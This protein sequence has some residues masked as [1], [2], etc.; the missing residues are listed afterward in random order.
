MII[1]CPKCSTKFQLEESLARP[2]ARARCNFCGHVFV[3][4][5]GMDNLAFE[6]ISQTGA[7][8][9]KETVDAIIGEGLNYNVDKIQPKK[10]KKIFPLILILLILI[11]GGAGAAVYTGL[12]P[13]DFFAEKQTDKPAITDSNATDAISTNSNATGTTPPQPPQEDASVKD[14]ILTDVRMFY[15]NNEKIGQLFVIEGKATN[16]FKTPKELIKVEATL[17]D[18][19]EHVLL[20]KQQFCGVVVSMFQL[21]V[22]SAEDLDKA[23][24]NKIEI[25]SN[26]INLQPGAS[27]PFMIVFT[28]APTTVREFMLKIID[29][30][31]PSN[32]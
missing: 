19:H 21:Q 2:L 5:D 15:V 20:S 30:K 10:R 1:T 31:D 17:L 11:L 7:P 28:D 29:A 24:N 25:L 14:I 4:A 3:M 32:S 6:A 18:E 9:A 12:I 13:L 27:V 26:N 23:L 8:S 16:N 22:L